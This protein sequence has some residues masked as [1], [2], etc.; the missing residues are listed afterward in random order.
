MRTN[1]IRIPYGVKCRVLYVAHVI[2]E[3]GREIN[4]TMRRVK[5]RG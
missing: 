2:E 1:G 5:N 3:G 4:V